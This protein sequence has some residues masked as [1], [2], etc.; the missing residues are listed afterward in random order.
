MTEF[1]WS[2][3]AVEAARAVFWNTAEVGHQ[4]F[5][6]ALTAAARAQGLAWLA[7]EVVRLREALEL[8]R[9]C[10]DDSDPAPLPQPAQGTCKDCPAWVRWISPTGQH[11]PR[12][13]C[14]AELPK[15]MEW[16]DQQFPPMHEDG[17]CLPGRRMMRDDAS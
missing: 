3:E 6:Q 7:D 15:R 14:R 13:E 4:R 10:I 8:A 12:G 9:E 11:E 5:L 2:E 1:V 17:W 16:E